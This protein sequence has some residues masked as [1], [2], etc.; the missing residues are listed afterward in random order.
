[1]GSFTEDLPVHSTLKISVSTKKKQKPPSSIT[2][3]KSHKAPKKKCPSRQEKRANL[4]RKSI[5]PERKGGKEDP[6]SRAEENA[7]FDQEG[8]PSRNI[9]EQNAD[10]REGKA[11]KGEVV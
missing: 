4:E 2:R 9:Y 11:M 8:G 5:V 6:F 3:R 1:M 7:R 10:Q